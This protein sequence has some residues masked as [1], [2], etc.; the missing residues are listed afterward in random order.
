MRS[1]LF[2]ALLGALPAV[3]APQPAAVRNFHA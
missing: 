2:T 3:M 1:S